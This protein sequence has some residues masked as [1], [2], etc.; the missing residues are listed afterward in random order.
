MRLGLIGFGAIGSALLPMLER[1]GVAPVATLVR[2]ERVREA[3]AGVSSL[4]AFLMARPTLVVEAAGQGAAREHGPAILGA[5]I[6]LVLASVGALA[7][8]AVERD[9]RAAA[10]AG[11]AR[12]ILP[13][14]AA[15]G[16]DALSAMAASGP[17]EVEYVGTK[18]PLAWAGTPAD[19]AFDLPALNEAT[20]IFEG[21]AREAA[22]AYPKNANVAATLALAGAGFEATRVR[23]V[24]DPAAKGNGHAFTARSGGSTLS[25]VIENAALPGNAKTSAATVGSLFRAVR[26][27]MGPISL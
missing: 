1:I 24:A 6:P 20:T 18:P 16:L 7:D 11:G 9:L 12:L 2:I 19:T 21:T 15:G 10:E 13:S 26:N 5:G 22:R 8:P 14:G 17:V 27:E 4:A 23:L 3:P 25:V